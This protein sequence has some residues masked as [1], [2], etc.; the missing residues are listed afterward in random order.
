[1]ILFEFLKKIERQEVNY[2]H[3]IVMV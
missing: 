2:L 1:V 3:S